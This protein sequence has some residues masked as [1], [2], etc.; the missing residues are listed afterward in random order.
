MFAINNSLIRHRHR[1]Q[2]AIDPSY[3]FIQS[4]RHVR[5][6]RICRIPELMMNR[7]CRNRRFNESH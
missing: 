5:K 4:Y 1:L 3:H 7:Y 6:N 2:V